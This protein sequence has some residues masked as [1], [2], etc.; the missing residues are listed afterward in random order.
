MGVGYSPS[1]GSKSTV[2][3]AVCEVFFSG[4]NKLEPSQ[5]VRVT[6]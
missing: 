1:D 5:L 6:V 4:F 3:V 2:L